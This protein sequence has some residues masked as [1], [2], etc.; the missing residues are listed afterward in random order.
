MSDE[1]LSTCHCDGASFGD[2]RVHRPRRPGRS[3]RLERRGGRGRDRRTDGAQRACGTFGRVLARRQ[4]REY[5]GGMSE[6]LPRLQ[7]HRRAVRDERSLHGVSGQRF[8]RV[9]GNR[10]DNHGSGL[11]Q[12]PRDRRPP[13]ARD[14]QRRRRRRW[15][16]RQPRQRGASVPQ[17]DDR[18]ALDRHLPRQCHRRRGLLHDVPRGDERERS[19]HH[20]P[21]VDA[22]FLPAPDLGRRR[23]DQHREEPID[24]CGHGHPGERAERRQLRS[25]GHV[26]VLPPV[27]RRR[28]ELPHG[29]GKRHY[30]RLL[31]TARGATGGS[32]HGR[33]RLPVRREDLRRGDPRAEALVR[34]LPHGPDGGQQQRPR[35][36]VHPAA[37]RV[38]GLPRGGDEL[39]HERLRDRRAE[40]AHPDG[41]LAQRR[42][43][44][45]ARDR[46]LR[47]SR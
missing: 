6:P 39:R 23:R 40:R 9:A 8:V 41:D 4:R 11:R 3:R 31:G 44:P 30:E 26:H 17:S 43:A 10:V 19:P 46:P 14:G 34:R 18:R 37:L 2:P 28:D 47:T 21:P 13:A 1:R 33:R 22:R 20:G 36:L 38:P 12:L 35:P 42:R 27:A 15:C 24:G 25:R 32:L 45:H 16:H 5:P 7:R 29:H